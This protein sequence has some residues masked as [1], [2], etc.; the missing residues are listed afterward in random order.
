MRLQT[1]RKVYFS[2][3]HVL[4]LLWYTLIFFCCNDL[5]F[6][7]PLSFFTSELDIT[8]W[9]HIRNKTIRWDVDRCC[10]MAI[11]HI[12]LQI[13]FLECIP[14]ES[15]RYWIH[16]SSK[17]TCIFVIYSQ[18]MLKYLFLSSPRNPCLY[19]PMG[20]RKLWSTPTNGHCWLV[21]ILH[22]AINSVWRD[23]PS[24]VTSHP[25]THWV[26][27]FLLTQGGMQMG[28]QRCLLTI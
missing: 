10:L 12:H 27:E 13:Y 2:R 17:V 11:V 9:M 6:Q 18:M 21:N 3:A 24:V 1:K 20:P 4:P 7:H 19:H 16:C 25:G 5:Y 28:P 8:D 22:P 15:M 14:W 26:Q 23:N